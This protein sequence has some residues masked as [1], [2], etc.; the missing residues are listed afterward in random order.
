M[1]FSCFIS[2][3]ERGYLLLRMPVN[4]GNVVS[5]LKMKMVELYMFPVLELNSQNISGIQN[6]AAA[7]AA[8]L[9]EE[10]R[11]E[12]KEERSNWIILRIEIGGSCEIP[13]QNE[14]GLRIY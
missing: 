4:N 5:L 2:L 1:G 10:T 7:H 9:V 3:L 11:Q 13:K 6:C 8:I 12:G 14:Q